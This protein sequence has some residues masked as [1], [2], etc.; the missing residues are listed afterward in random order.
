MEEDDDDFYGGGGSGLH[1]EYAPVKGEE[2][3]SRDEQMDVSDQEEEDED[4]SDDVRT[5]LYRRKW[6]TCINTAI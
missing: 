4:D 3:G 2:Y 6:W 5:I 1:D